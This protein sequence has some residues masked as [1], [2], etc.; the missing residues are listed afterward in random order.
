MTGFLVAVTAAALLIASLGGASS[1]TGAVV[2]GVLGLLAIWPLACLVW[3]VVLLLRFSQARARASS[4]LAQEIDRCGRAGERV[5]LVMLRF[6]DLR[7]LDFPFFPSRRGALDSLRVHFRSYDQIERVGFN[8][9]VMILPGTDSLGVIA[10]RERLLDAIRR[11]HRWRIRVGLSVH[12]E[13]GLTPD[14]LLDH[15]ARHCA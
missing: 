5:V 1:L 8:S 9:Y 13:D 15:A 12:P 4:R 3:S 6:P 14:I 2:L 11:E 10:V 7:T